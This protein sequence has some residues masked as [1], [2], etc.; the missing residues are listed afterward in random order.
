MNIYLGDGNYAEV[1]PY[2]ENYVPELDQ[3]EPIII[4]D[5]LPKPEFP[6]LG[7]GAIVELIPEKARR[8]IFG[9]LALLSLLGG[10]VAGVVT[11][12]AANGLILEATAFTTLTVLTI[13]SSV[14]TALVGALG[15]AA[16]SEVTVTPIYCAEGVGNGRTT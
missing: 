16:K 10:I 15:F 1:E 11:S 14:V 2:S 13:V 9:V 5:E 12:L 4:E 7:W 6:D 3:N 8:V